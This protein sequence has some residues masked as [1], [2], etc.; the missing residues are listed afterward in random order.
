MVDF[1]KELEVLRDTTVGVERD[2]E[3]KKIEDISIAVIRLCHG[4]AEQGYWNVEFDPSDYDGEYVTK[5]MVKVKEAGFEVVYSDLYWI[6][7][8]PNMRV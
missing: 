5:V 6:K 2:K 1:K 8:K 3:E 7:W 4:A